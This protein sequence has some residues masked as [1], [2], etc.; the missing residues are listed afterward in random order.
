[1]YGVADPMLNPPLLCGLGTG[2]S[3]RKTTGGVVWQHCLDYFVI[4]PTIFGRLLHMTFN[5]YEHC[6]PGRFD[7]QVNNLTLIS[8][9]Y[10]YI[11]IIDLWR[12]F[13]A[14][15]IFKE[16][17]MNW[18]FSM[19]SCYAS[20]PQLSFNVFFRKMN[21]FKANWNKKIAICSLI[22]MLYISVFRFIIF[23]II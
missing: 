8:G 15:C 2:I 21:T 3:R 4:S 6:I 5:W 1:M 18:L 9:Y 22:F 7:H 23:T 13:S 14:T 17:K 20:N 16:R 11:V 10:Y 19:N 12:I